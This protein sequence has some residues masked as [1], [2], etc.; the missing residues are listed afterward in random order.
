MTMKVLTDQYNLYIMRLPKP[1]LSIRNNTTNTISLTKDQRDDLNREFSKKY[2]K[3]KH[4]PEPSAVQIAKMSSGPHFFSN[5]TYQRQ[6]CNKMVNNVI[7]FFICTK[8][9]DCVVEKIPSA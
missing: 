3:F 1:N 4:G 7:H 6:K 2:R 8:T 9:Y 5:N